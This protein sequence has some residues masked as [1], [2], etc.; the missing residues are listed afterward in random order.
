MRSTADSLKCPTGLK[1]N[2]GVGLRCFNF[3]I[4]SGPLDIKGMDTDQH[5][6]YRMTPKLHIP[7]SDL[8]NRSRGQ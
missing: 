1:S 8:L 7:H 3:S 6:A 2:G 4:R 5:D